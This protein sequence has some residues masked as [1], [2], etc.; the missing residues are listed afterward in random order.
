M[1]KV[2]IYSYRENEADNYARLVT[3]ANLP[4]L[5]LVVCRK[6]QEAAAQI[7]HVDALFSVHLPPEIYELAGENLRWIQSMWA[8]VDNLMRA[9]IPANTVITKP[10]GV[11]GQYLAQYVFGYFLAERIKLQSSLASQAACRWQPYQL[12]PIIGQRIGIAGMGD[13]G[14]F[15]ARVAKSFEMQVWALN[16]TAKSHPNVDRS[17]GIS[18]IT[19]FAAGLDLLVSLLPATPETHGLIGQEV[20]AALPRHAMLIN[21]GRGT[22]IDDAALIAALRAERLA[23][24]VLDVFV[25]E[26]LPSDHPYWKLPRCIVTPHIGGPS[27]PADITRCFVTNYYRF[28]HGEPLLATID[29]QRGY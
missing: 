19:D 20:L 25:Q 18:E 17:F 13:I 26:P 9:N 23:G 1:P 3:Q 21:V 16:H 15:L 8:G 28:L 24:A 12:S 22:N 4:E 6:P 29:R 5:E 11:F 14:S 27:L 7:S 2:L 10:W